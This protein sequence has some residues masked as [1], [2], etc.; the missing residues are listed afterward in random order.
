MA[1]QCLLK[2]HPA[3]EMV[4]YNDAMQSMDEDKTIVT[5]NTKAKHKSCQMVKIIKDPLFWH[6][7]TWLVPIK[8]FIS[9]FID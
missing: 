5:G 2:L 8:Y 9:C 6:A 4:I 3:L 7:L 1:Y